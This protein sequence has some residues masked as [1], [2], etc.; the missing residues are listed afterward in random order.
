[1]TTIPNAQ[2]MDTILK[3]L[4]QKNGEVV[5]DQ[6]FLRC[7]IWS[8]QFDLAKLLGCTEDDIQRV[9]QCHPFPGPTNIRQMDN[10]PGELFTNAAAVSSLWQP[11]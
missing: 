3:F 5:C 9:F 10:N 1:M 2:K 6:V 11:A 4:Q 7:I 8:R